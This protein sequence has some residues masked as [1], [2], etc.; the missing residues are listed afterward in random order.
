MA[1]FKHLLPKLLL[2]NRQV[3]ERDRLGKITI[4]LSKGHDSEIA[5]LMAFR[6][7]AFEGRVWVGGTP[8]LPAKNWIRHA[9]AAG[10]VFFSSNALPSDFTRLPPP[11]KLRRTGRRD[12][13]DKKAAVRTTLIALIMRIQPGEGLVDINRLVSIQGHGIRRQSIAVILA[14]PG[15]GRIFLHEFFQ[16]AFVIQQLEQVALIPE[17]PRH[18]ARG[19]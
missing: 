9:S 14:Y 1:K 13:T 17:F 6:F 12:G 19:P 18:I 2:P 5:T 7:C 16:L 4:P 15:Q 11:L 3:N 8:T 10:H